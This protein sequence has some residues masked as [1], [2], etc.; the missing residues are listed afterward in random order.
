MIDPSP[1]PS[2][3]RVLAAALGLMTLPALSA[4]TAEQTVG[5]SGS[6]AAPS[7]SGS[8]GA[9]A[10]GAD[11]FRNTDLGCG[12]EPVSQVSLDYATEFTLDEYEGGYLLACIANGE[13]FLIVPEGADAPDGFAE[14]IAVIN[15]PARD[16]YLVSTGMICLI[17]E[18]GALDAVTVTSVT[19]EDSPADGLTQRIED[20]QISYGGLYRAPDFELIADAGCTLA[21]ENTNIDHVPDVKRKLQ[22]LGVAVLTEQSSHEGDC[23]GR[24]EWIRLMGALFDREAEADERFR[25]IAERVESAADQEPTGK[26]VAFFY[27]NSDGAAVTR[28]SGDY[29]SQMI[30]LAGGTYLAFDP[31]QGT[32]SSP[33]TVTV[34]MESFYSGARDADVIIY[35]NT[36]DDGVASIADL[37]G[38]NELLG[39]LRAVQ[40]GNVWS[41]D[42]FMYQRMTDM[43]DII[44][45]MRAAFTGEPSPARFVWK[46]D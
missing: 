8:P 2:R 26:T 46:L 34:E 30:E 39:Q 40:E 19:A 36:I 4:C 9:D 11:G 45:E 43:A 3:R 27:V 16:V 28:R 35:N 12:W 33:T 1:M 20:G 29:F 32:D 38:K 21:I 7:G 23:L 44:G 14:D 25:E 6:T 37:V 10:A 22:E 31:G 15:R 17:D 18:I 24:L 5:K 41:V 42:K 13:R